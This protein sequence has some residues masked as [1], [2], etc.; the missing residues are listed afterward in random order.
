MTKKS[1]NLSKTTG[2]VLSRRAAVTD[3]AIVA[4]FMVT[5]NWV[6]LGITESYA[7]PIT[8]SC[9]VVLITMLFWRRGMRWRDHGLRRPTRPRLLFAQV[10]VVLVAWLTISAVAAFLVGQYLPKPDTSARFGDLAGNIPGT[11]WW[12]GIA[13]LIGGFA[14]EMIFRGFLLNRLAALLPRGTLGSI[15]AV[16]LQA[17]LFG[18]VHVYNRGLFGFLVL[19]AVGL[20]LGTSYLVLRRNLWPLI[21]AHGLGN[22]LGFLARYF[23]LK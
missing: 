12:I 15:M 20:V 9:A 7:G 5:L 4:A 17:A 11:L 16:L 10:P 21:L 6:T 13:W 19:G 22:T 14:E 8:A 2:E 1:L 3:I 23:D 18:A